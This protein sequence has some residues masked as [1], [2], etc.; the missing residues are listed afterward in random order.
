MIGKKPK[1]F[2]FWSKKVPKISSS[3]LNFKV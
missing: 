3:K 2:Q 1:Q